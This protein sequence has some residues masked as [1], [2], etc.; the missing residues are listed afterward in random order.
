M[1]TTKPAPI[2]APPSAAALADAALIR[3]RELRA[4]PSRSPSQQAELLD[5]LADQVLGSTP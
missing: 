1:A 4:M 5:L 3:I 2:V